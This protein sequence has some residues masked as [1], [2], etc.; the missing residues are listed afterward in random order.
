[1]NS[2][3]KYYR[4]KLYP[5]QDGILKLVNNLKTPFYLTGGTA[6]GRYYLNHRYSDDLDFFVNNEKNYSKYVQL[7]F[8]AIE[9]SSK[10]FDFLIDY[11]KIKRSQYFTQIFLILDESAFL[12]IDLINDVARHFG[13]FPNDQILGKVDNWKNILSNKITAL[14]RLEAKDVVDIWFIAHAFSFNWMDIVNQAKIKEAGLDIINIFDMIN[15]FPEE[16]LDTVKWTKPVDKTHFMNDLKFLA[17][18]I[19]EGAENSLYSI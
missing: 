9:K 3:E 19:F 13:S 5:F 17:K 6:L 14:Y 12:K 2:Y 1:M 8:T 11:P 15:S 4:E 16:L 10:E 7:I 18:D